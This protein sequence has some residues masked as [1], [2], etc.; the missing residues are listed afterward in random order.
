LIAALN[1]NAQL[2]RTQIP[3]VYFKNA[4]KE[5]ANQRYMYA[6]PFYRASLKSGRTS[7]SL[8]TLHL[9][10]CYWRMKNYDSAL[11][12]FREYEKKFAPLYSTHQKMAELQANLGKYAE[13]A[14]TYKLLQADLPIRNA[15]LLSERYKGFSNVIPFLRDSTDYT[16][17]L[18]KLNTKQQDFSPQFY[19]D[20][21][22]FVSNRYS[23]REG[24]RQFGWDGLPYANIYWIKDTSTLVVTDAVEGSAAINLKTGIKVNDDFTE[25][26]SNDNNTINILRIKG[27]YKGDLFRLAK[28][29]DD[30]TTKYNYG[31]LCFNRAGT[32]LYFTRNSKKDYQGR[33]NLEICEATLEHGEWTNIKVMPF[34]NPA[35]DYYH[36]A[37]SGD[38][39]TLYFCSNKPDGYGGSDIWYVQLGSAA[40]R[41]A[42]F[43][44]GEA[45]NTAGDELFPT[46]NGE[47]LYFS[48]DGLAGLGGLDIF[49]TS[50]DKRGRWTKP[51]N[52]GY[53][54]NSSF[55]DFGVI[56]TTNGDKG[57]FSSNRL[58]SDDIYTFA[59]VPVV[60]NLRSTVFN[61]ATMR[62]L[63]RAS[64][65]IT[66]IEDGVSVPVD[67]IT[68]DLTGNFRFPAK[69]GRNYHFEVSREGFTGE[70]VNITA[71]SKPEAETELQPVLLTPIPQE[72]EKD[73]DS[74]GVP[75]VKDKCPDIKGTKELNG[76]PDIQKRLNE[77]AKMVF[78][79]TDKSDILS[80]SLNPLNEAAEILMQFPNTTL[81]IEGHTDSR[82]SAAHNKA[83]SQRR[84]NA[85]KTYLVN[86]GIAASRFTS[87]VGYGLERP[88]ATNATDEGRAMNRRVELKATFVQ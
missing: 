63:D 33:Y 84:A 3:G 48:S 36:P 26:T 72:P 74:D 65:I 75:D 4:E 86:K 43:N 2:T 73:R 15:R 66:L 58:G 22:V 78:F 62:R 40:E 42:A 41:A 67:T 16:I 30:L 39:K 60:M 45:V 38:E 70:S 9:A 19:R 14:A 52:L 85:V 56:Q 76:C 49:Q 51:A 59:H 47:N 35:Y 28:F 57:Y 32:K 79:D 61:K 53:P 44:L 34:V 20:G 23:R 8:A 77:L 83:L 21:M 69:P 55:D 27:D 11:I 1:G 88:I 50:L 24:E 80:K 37:L 12:F 18:L 82:A 71:P 46:V 54:L 10:D 31:P 81:V 13:A 87:V 7:D 6:V 68:T 64:V 17:G 5:Y 25:R 29:G